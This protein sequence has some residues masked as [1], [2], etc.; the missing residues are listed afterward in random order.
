M[1]IR[2]AIQT[3]TDLLRSNL[4]SYTERAFHRL[5]KFERPRILDIGCGSGIAT[6]AITRISGGDTVAIDIEPTLLELLKVRAVKA[7]LGDRIQSLQCSVFDLKF[8]AKSKE[9][10]DD[11]ETNKYPF[12]S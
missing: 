10:Y 9:A 2:A 12:C 1:D 11:Y 6:V 3:E 8:P 7:G 5:P 4:L